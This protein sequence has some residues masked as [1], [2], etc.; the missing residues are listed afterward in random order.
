MATSS[1]S[2]ARQK[3]REEL[4]DLAA[5]P[6]EKNDLI[7]KRFDIAARLR[8]EAHEGATDAA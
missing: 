3:T 5:D 8:P 6:D 4:Y 1:T 2:T 7:N